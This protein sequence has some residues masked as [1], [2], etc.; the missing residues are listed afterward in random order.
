MTGHWGGALAGPGAGPLP[1]EGVCE[2]GLKAG[3]E[4]GDT[5]TPARASRWAPPIRAGTQPRQ[6]RTRELLAWVGCRSQREGALAS[7]SYCN[8]SP[9]TEGLKITRNRFSHSSRGRNPKSR[10]Q[11][12]RGPS[13][14]SGENPSLP[15]WLLVAPGIPWHV[16]AKLQSLPLSSRGLLCVPLLIRTPAIGFRA[17]LTQYDLISRPLTNL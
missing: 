9:Q 15:L 17:T 1:K 11:Q 8:K 13:R 3:V 12:G 6:Q 5:G 10:C 4:K 2:P 7:C 14:G 16:A